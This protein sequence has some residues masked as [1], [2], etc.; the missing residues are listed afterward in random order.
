LGLE[1]NG[2]TYITLPLVGEDGK[3]A[4]G[5]NILA[6]FGETNDYFNPSEKPVMLNLRVADLFGFLEE[7][8]NKKVT[9]VGEP[10]SEEYGKFGWILD[11][12]GHKIELWE[13]PKE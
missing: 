6:F 2:G 12:E 11:P 4:P 1:F 3:P 8:K 5:Y 7:L 13:P 9:I 10:M